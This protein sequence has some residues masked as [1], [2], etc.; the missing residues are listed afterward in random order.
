[1]T[2]QNEIFAFENQYRKGLGVTRQILP[3]FDFIDDYDQMRKRIDVGLFADAAREIAALHLLTPEPLQLFPDGSN[4]IFAHGKN[5]V[6]KLFPHLL[7]D[8]YESERIVLKHLESKLTVSTPKLL[9]EGA[10]DG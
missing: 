7:I 10:I 4:V 6:I 9:H 1:M 5:Q 8:Q 2:E 3:R